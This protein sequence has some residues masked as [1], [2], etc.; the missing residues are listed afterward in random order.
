[1]KRCFPFLMALLLLAAC[2]KKE[3][4]LT[5]TFEKSGFLETDSYEGTISFAKQLAKQ[6]D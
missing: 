4:D 5:T 6:F 3:A 1:M 2:Q